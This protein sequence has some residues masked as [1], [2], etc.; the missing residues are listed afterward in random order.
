MDLQNLVLSEDLRDQFG[1]A[2][3]SATA[4]TIVSG[5]SF[6]TS[7]I[8]AGLINTSWNGLTSL[9]VFDSTFGGEMLA[10][11]DQFTIEFDVVVDPD[12]NDDNADYLQNTATISGD[13]TNFDGSTITVSDDSGVDNGNG[14]DSDEPTSAIIPEIAIVK[15]AGDAIANGDDW[16]VTF[17]LVVENTGSVN[18]N[19]LTLLDDISSQL[20]NAFVSVS[21][22]SINNFAGAG[23]A[24]AVNP[25]WAN[26]NTSAS[27]ISGG[28]LD[29]GDRFEVVYTVTIDPDRIDSMSQALNNQATI[30]GDTVDQMGNPLLSDLGT[31]LT[32]GD[33][34]DDGS[35]PQGTNPGENGDTG[36]DADPTPIIIADTSIAKQVIGQPTILANGNFAVTYQLA[37]ENI[38]TVNLSNLTLVDDLET[39]FGTAVF[40]GVSGLNI[41]APPANANSSISLNTA[42]WDG[43]AATDILDQAAENHLAIGD[44]FAIQFTVEVDAGAA[45]GVLNNQATISGTAVDSNGD[46]YTNAAGAPITSSDDSDSGPTTADNN[47][48][49][50]GDTGGSDDP[51]PTYIPNIG[52]AKQAGAPVPNGDN[53]DVVFTLVWENT[54]NVTLNDLTLFD[55]V[56]AQFGNAFLAASGLTVQNFSGTGTAPVANTN[57]NGNT[58]L[59]MIS[60]GTANVGDSFEVVF[61]VTIDPDGFDGT[62]QALSNQATA[63][64]DALDE[65]GNAIL[66]DSGN[67]IVASDVSDNGSNPNDENGVSE[68][69]DGIH[70]ND[71]TPVLIADVSVVKSVV[72]IS[73]ELPNGNFDV[74]YELI[75]ENTGTLDLVNLTLVED[76]TTHFGT[77]LY[78]AGNLRL[79]A[80]PAN[81][82]SSIT[83]NSTSW[84]GNL[85][86]EMIDQTVASSL[87]V[88]DSFTVRFT[89][90]V[91]PDAVGAPQGLDNQVTVG[92]T[93]T[94]STGNF[95]VG[96]DGTPVTTTD[97]SDSG[98]NPNSDNPNAAGDNQTSDDPTPLLLPDVSLA[99]RAGDAVPN[100]E[101]YD[102]TF[103]LVFANTGTTTLNNLTL[104]DDIAAEFGNTLVG[105]SNLGVQN[106]SGTGTAPT[107]NG[108]WLADTTES[109]ISGGTLH[110]GDR[111]E[112][113]F[114]TTIDPN[115]DGA[116]V[117]LDNQAVATANGLDEN[118]NP[119]LDTNGDP[120]LTSDESDNGANPSDENGSE[121]TADG[122]FANDP[123][124][125]QI[126]DLSIAKAVV[127]EP[128][129]LWNGNAVVTYRLIVENTGTVDLANLSLI[130]D[131]ESQF[132]SVFRDAGNLVIS[133][134]PTN[135]ASSITLNSAGW[136][137]ATDLELIDV[138]ASNLL[139]VGDSF[140]LEFTAEV[141]ALEVTGPLLNQVTGVAQGTDT[142]G[143][144]LTDSS[145]NPLNAD[146]VSDN[147]QDPRS[148]NGE[149][150]SDGI[151]GNDPTPVNIELDPTGFFY[152]ESTGEILTGGSISVAGPGPGTVNLVDDGDDGDYQFFGTTPGTYV[153]T[154]TAPPGFEL[155]LDQLSGTPLDPT[156]LG[157]PFLLGSS[158]QDGDGFLDDTTPTTYYL[159]FDLN[160]GDPLLLNNNLPFRRASLGAPGVSGNPP[161]L[162]F[163]PP[164]YRSPI[165]GLLS[166]YIGAP[167]PIYSGIPVNSNANPLSLDSGR[168]VTGGYS[169]SGLMDDCA[170]PAPITPACQPIDPCGQFGVPVD[171]PIMHIQDEVILDD[172]CPCDSILQTTVAPETDPDAI[173]ENDAERE[174]EAELTQVDSDSSLTKT[175]KREETIRRP[176]FLKKIA[177]WFSA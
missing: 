59:S 98:T 13:G 148:E 67:Q 62:S 159:E 17:T 28:D 131:L 10:A 74:Q 72:G 60:G 114:T 81:A 4:P 164:I 166:S 7:N 76:L 45:T 103:T 48:G 42:N 51:T 32:A 105:I 21:G 116:S 57:W 34:S 49:Q 30:G 96:P 23:T 104:T 120:V 90:Q 83:L 95:I 20:G 27:L 94:D 162:P 160:I 93:A 167:G 136:D 125:I 141:N 3:I 171:G 46:V 123:T 102:I 144:L 157:N 99:K 6:P 177:T 77:A 121:D 173:S 79:E 168:A 14:I 150:D 101:D 84:D 89:V 91:D 44:S 110:V 100:G 170:C 154:V 142:A 24:P 143:N 88:G 86:T 169:T 22:L 65:N 130:E 69:N 61:T 108:G 19:N 149:D 29:P 129:L 119:L 165:A 109:L 64:G 145:G 1:D 2:F 55:D 137:G 68:T 75:I 176:W 155:A 111:F 36:T 35:N 126:A 153:V 54:G 73:S 127:G 39:Q 40:Q 174:T 85:V 106:F 140:A 58:A 16:N 71:P 5:P 128:N 112:V 138:S 158:D 9:D 47:V 152:D 52:L 80:G 163:I 43:T 33:V 92:G 156:G 147:G 172:D 26:N 31:Q 113:V 15:R 135:P 56:R 70:A 63:F 118:G 146:D 151:F 12:L 134:A 122:V 161:Q 53:F 8:P 175:H 82:G 50:P 107:V 124:P 133:A 87:A 38:G 117:S 25:A 97:D 115:A 78:S 41:F 37:V 11:G 139:A 66:D 132:G 18:L